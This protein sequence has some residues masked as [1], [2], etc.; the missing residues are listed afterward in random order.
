MK[1]NLSDY[2]QADKLIDQ[3]TPDDL[4]SY[5]L[6]GTKAGLDGEAIHLP[7]RV[8]IALDHLVSCIEW[9]WGSIGC[10][11]NLDIRECASPEYAYTHQHRREAFAGTTV[12][13]K[14][15]TEEYSDSLL[16][17][18]RV[19]RDEFLKEESDLIDDYG[20]EIVD[21][22]TGQDLADRYIVASV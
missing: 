10:S 3:M 8:A 4:F 20:Q 9:D 14:W 16:E 22:V 2:L 19:S 13:P 7:K 11:T 12:W 6:R 18:N 17:W 5:W 21:R 1:L 15:V